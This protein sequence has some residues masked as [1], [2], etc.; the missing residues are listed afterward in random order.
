MN[1]KMIAAWQEIYDNLDGVLESKDITLPTKVHIGKAVISRSHVERE[2]D[3]KEGRVLKNWCFQTVVLEKTQ[4]S[5]GQQEDQSW[6][7]STLNTHWK[8]WY[9][10][11]SFNTSATWWEQ[12]THWKILWCWERLKAEGEEGNRGW[13]G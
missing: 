11:W 8:D 7:K 5:L 9:W 4:E 13:D 10:S 12:L 6:K 1:Y 3:H 2:L